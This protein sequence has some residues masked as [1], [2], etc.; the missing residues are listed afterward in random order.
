[1]VQQDVLQR[2][3]NPH[4]SSMPGKSCR[5][6]AVGSFG[7]MRLEKAVADKLP[8]RT[9]QEG[10]AIREPEVTMIVEKT[11]HQLAVFLGLQRTGS[12]NQGAAPEQEPCRLVQQLPLGLPV[13]RDIGFSPVPADV[14]V[15]A[16]DAGP[17]AGGIDQDG[18]KTGGAS[19][20][21][22]Q[23]GAGMNVN[24]VQRMQAGQVLL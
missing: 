21:E 13:L 20:R 1:M 12:I 17:R 18:C 11:G 7:G 5:E 10:C 6:K 15:A 16:D 22:I 9:R 4:I 3:E 23:Q 14:G 2:K 19:L 8:G 24:R